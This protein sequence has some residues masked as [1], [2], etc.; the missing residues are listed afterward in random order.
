[1]GIDYLRDQ[2]DEEDAAEADRKAR[3][4]VEEPS[5]PTKFN[6]NTQSAGASVSTCMQIM[7]EYAGK[8]NERMMDEKPWS[9][10]YNHLNEAESHID[11]AEEAF[12]HYI[13]FH[14]YD[15]DQGGTSRA[16]CSYCQE[17]GK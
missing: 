17:E 11:S 5:L 13:M 6:A 14:V 16:D 7:Y 1:M 2:A 15:G 8:S 12:S 3:G 9:I 4:E 10:V